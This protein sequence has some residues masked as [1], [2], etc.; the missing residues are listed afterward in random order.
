M[1]GICWDHKFELLNLH[2]P[3]A[4]TNFQGAK[5]IYAFKKHFKQQKDM[6]APK[7]VVPNFEKNIKM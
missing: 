3:S 1:I 2:N 6:I 4:P 5:F 7:I